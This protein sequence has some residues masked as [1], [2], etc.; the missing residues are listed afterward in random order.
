MPHVTP[1]FEMKNGLYKIIESK[2]QLPMIFRSRW[3]DS[4]SVP[5]TTNFTWRL[6][7]RGDTEKPTYIIVGFQ[8]NKHESQ[9]TNPALFDHI[10]VKSIY[11]MLNSEQ[12]PEVD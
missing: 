4:I 9:E 12:Y 1:S 8:T 6:G 2:T 10:N 5:H 11:A 7:S 3:C